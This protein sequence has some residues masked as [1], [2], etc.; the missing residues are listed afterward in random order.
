[1]F[2]ADISGTHWWHSH[3]GMQR[4][5]GAFGAF[6]IREPVTEIPIQIQQ[7]TDNEDTTGFIMMMQD[8]EHVVGVAGFS[9]FHHSI[10][11][12][13]PKN[14]LINGKGRYSGLKKVENS[15]ENSQSKPTFLNEHNADNIETIPVPYEVFNVKKGSKYRFRTIN[16]GFLNCPLE[17]SID[18]HTLL[19][20]SSDGHYIEPVEVDLLVSYAGERFD[21]IV[22]ANQPIGNYW[23]RVK[24]LMDCDERFTKAHQGAI[25]RYTGAQNM[26][27]SE[28]LTYEFKRTGFQMNSLNKGP[29]HIDSVAIVEATALEPDT[30]ELMTEHTD[31]KFFV[32]YDFYDRDFPRFNHPSLYNMQSVPDPRNKFYGPQ[33]NQITFRM[34]STPFLMGRDERKF[35]NKSSLAQQNIDC[36][37]QFCECTHVLQVPLNATVEIILVDEGFMYDANHPFHLHGHHFRVVGMERVQATGITVDKVSCHF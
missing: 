31:Y 16:S 2:N 29:N 33:L 11:N 27:P 13:K 24:G 32:H 28:K 6:I 10:G 35:C 8:W 15:T 1:M 21:F 19:V 36:D 37:K 34:P 22:T 14:I 26:I 9:S 3:V 7:A 12:N 25:F 5:D 4:S 18:N 23:V 17:I 20:I 30:P